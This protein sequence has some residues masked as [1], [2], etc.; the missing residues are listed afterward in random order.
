MEIRRTDFTSNIRI[1]PTEDNIT[2]LEVLR[3]ALLH[4]NLGDVAHGGSLLPAHGVLVLL[5]RGARR[6]ADGVELEVRVLGEEEDEALADGASGAED[7][8]E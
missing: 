6:G 5:A 4:D 2:L 8:C 1:Q 7:T 3:L